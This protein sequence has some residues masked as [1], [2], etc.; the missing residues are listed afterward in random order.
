MRPHAL[1]R[2]LL[3]IGLAAGRNSP[4]GRLRFAA[5]ITAAAVVTLV[6]MSCLAVIATCDGWDRRD[7]AR[8][9][10]IARHGDSPVVALYKRAGDSVGTRPHEVV[11]IEPKSPQASPPP[12]LPRWPEPGEAFLSPELV[13]VGEGEGITRRY[14]KFAGIIDSS[15]LATPSERLAYVRPAVT[16]HHGW[17]KIAKIGSA[18]STPMGDTLNRVPAGQLLSAIGFT[19]GGVAI[20]LLVVAARCGSSS[21]DRRVRL[22][23]ALGGNRWHLALVNLG[24]ACIP[25]VIGTLLG[26]VPY[27]LMSLWDV[28]IPLI[29]QVVGS[30][31]LRAWAW[32]T[33]M[34]ALAGCGLMLFVVVA[35]H[36]A[37]I[38]GGGTRPRVF[39]DRI[40]R[41]RL[42]AGLLGLI[43][44][45]TTPY[46]PKLTSFL[47]YI[48]GT[49]LLWGMLP[50]AAGAVIR[51]WGNSAASFGRWA[52]RA[53]VLIAGRWAHARPGVV[54]RLVA[55]MVIGLGVITQ[56]QVW[57]SR[58]GDSG[59][60]ARALQR[61]LH[62]S[63]L[64]VTP[65]SI[66][67]ASVD[68]FA[69]SL[70]KNANIFLV[71]TAK[72]PTEPS[73]LRGSCEAMRSLG[74]A[75]SSDG[76][77]MTGGD[78]RI[79]I[80][81]KFI[82][83]GGEIKFR[84]GNVS[85]NTQKAD[86]I[87][88]VSPLGTTGLNA[89]VKETA[90]RAFGLAQVKR[91]YDGWILGADRLVNMAD[92]V[93]LLTI[94]TLIILALAV[95]FSSAAEFLVFTAAVAPLAVLTERR[96][97][98]LGI[99]IWNLTVPTVI[100][101]AFGV[102]VA[103]WQGSFFISLSKSGMFSWSLLAACAAGALVLAIAI[104]LIGG[105][106]A[107]RATARWRPAAD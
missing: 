103:A 10:E 86:Q 72:K 95:A 41:W 47:A 42:Y 73:V 51:Y 4:G 97:F 52:G 69:R 98:L 78:A 14:G 37:G 1:W 61:E 101:V 8:G 6:L 75:C 71:N 40:P 64:V 12:G 33:P 18:R 79:A 65:Q 43:A 54:V 19:V 105:T 26:S 92:W 20:V 58:L 35:L 88:V 76:D 49:T 9:V 94:L 23:T 13:R 82:G 60:N 29:D 77:H 67:P 104:G 44:I 34:V 96:R 46:L 59:Q 48:A 38:D 91:P 17:S 30:A 32:V 66:T 93:K 31:D 25:V 62:D 56:A 80:L 84:E 63:V 36:L 55:V 15:G 22:L 87:A 70:P 81:G 5:L 100:A 21:R 102:C 90:N 2:Q 99:A 16:G 85:G 39:A 45:V 27:L 24:E 89:R 11:Y 7:V 74:I 28:R 83:F 68:A 106:G 57:T 107:I 53:D 50:S 3:R